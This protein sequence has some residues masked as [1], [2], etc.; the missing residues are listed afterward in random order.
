MDSCAHCVTV[1][2]L[3]Q[4]SSFAER[5]NGQA[6]GSI[7]T[8]GFYSLPKPQPGEPTHIINGGMGG[9]F[10]TAHFDPAKEKLFNLSSR[11]FHVGGSWGVA[12]QAE[13]DGSILHIGWSSGPGGRAGPG[14]AMMSAVK[15]L[16]YDQA[17][18]SLVG[19]PAGWYSK[20]H[21]G[22]LA[23][24]PLLKLGTMGDTRVYTPS[25][26]KGTHG[27]A[28]DLT[29]H[30]EL[31][32]AG[33]ASNV[34]VALEIKVLAT[35]AATGNA[36]SIMINI[37]ST[38]GAGGT[39]AGAGVRKGII[40]VT[41]SFAVRRSHGQAFDVL[42]GE[43]SVDLRVLTDRSIIEAFAMGGRASQTEHDYPAE[44]DSAFHLINWGVAPLVVRNLSIAS[45]ACGWV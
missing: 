29:L 28:S 37:T 44:G 11:S 35:G 5:G 42:A 41:P 26:P 3:P 30:L 43:S 1:S 32:P 9:E 40:S 10:Y 45:M 33:D 7:S 14:I 12:G 23:D 36:T 38:A 31:L 16:S 6:I 4:D 13:T 25:L 2:P 19:N 20:M 17:T 18:A 24:E 27:A 34:A 22:T 21:N 39:G 15:V 8:P